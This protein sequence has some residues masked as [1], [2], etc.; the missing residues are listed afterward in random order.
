LFSFAKRGVKDRI[1]RNMSI[2]VACN[3]HPQRKRLNFF[4]D[5]KKPERVNA[6]LFIDETILIFSGEVNWK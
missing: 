6:F 4:H 5:E 2:H 1:N 3:L